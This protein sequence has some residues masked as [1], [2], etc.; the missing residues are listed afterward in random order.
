MVFYAV[1][2]PART[3][4][5][6][7]RVSSCIILLKSD[8]LNTKLAFIY[9]FFLPQKLIE[10]LDQEKSDDPQAKSINNAFEETPTAQAQGGLN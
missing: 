8:L 5:D 9:I 1:S 10:S 2:V 4:C 3:W 7:L 6:P